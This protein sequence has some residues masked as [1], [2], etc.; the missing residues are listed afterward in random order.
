MP[1][2]STISD[3]PELTGNQC[4]GMAS[5]DTAAATAVP[6]SSTGMP[7][8]ISAPNTAISRTSVSGIEVSPGLPEIVIEHL[9]RDPVGTGAPRLADRQPGMLGL[10]PGHRRLVG[11][12]RSSW[13]PGS[14]RPRRR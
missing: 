1:M 11:Q 8:A 4:A 5:S 7:A 10:D 13:P 9:A 6:A 14:G 2:T 12:R 3:V